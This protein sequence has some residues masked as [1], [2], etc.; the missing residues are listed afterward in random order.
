MYTGEKLEK[1]KIL[2]EFVLEKKNYGL[3]K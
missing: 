2:V 1:E 3:N